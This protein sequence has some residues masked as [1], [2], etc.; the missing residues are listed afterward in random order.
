[1]RFA[2]GACQTRG[3]VE[4]GDR[5]GHPENGVNDASKDA[6]VCGAGQ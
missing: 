2:R 6:G 5:L 1:L 3:A 4:G